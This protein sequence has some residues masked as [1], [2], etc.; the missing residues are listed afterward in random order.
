M[1]DQV[2]SQAPFL[3]ED[4]L[5]INFTQCNTFFDRSTLQ[6]SQQQKTISLDTFFYFSFTLD[7]RWLKNFW[8]TNSR[9]SFHRPELGISQKNNF[10]GFRTLCSL[11]YNPVI[12]RCDRI[13]SATKSTFRKYTRITDLMVRHPD[14]HIQGLWRVDM[15][16]FRLEFVSS[17]KLMPLYSQA[18]FILKIG[19]RFIE[20]SNV[21]RRC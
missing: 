17:L 14:V 5:A 20:H 15:T 11:R 3:R 10:K 19:T 1:K 2:A 9:M 12:K 16:I 8:T 6:S 18:L 7:L 21:T 4:Q 13:S